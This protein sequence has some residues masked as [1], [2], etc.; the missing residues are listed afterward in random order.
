MTTKSGKQTHGLDRFFSSLFGKPVPG[1]AF[2]GLS[3]IDVQ[4][5]RS[6]PVM[7]EQVVRTEEE[8]TAAKQ[9]AQQRQPQK[10]Q[11]QE[12]KKPGRPKGSKNRNKAEVCLTPE[13]LRI[14]EMIKQFLLIAGQAIPLVYIARDRHF[15]NNN[16]LQMVLQCGLHLVSKLRCDS[17]LYFAYQGPDTRRKYGAR[18][19]DANIPAEYLKET[20]TQDDIRTDIYQM[21]AL[22]KE[23]AQPLNVVIIVK[24]NLKT[25]AWAHVV[26]F[27]S[28]LCQYSV[29][30]SEP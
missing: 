19:D 22:H 21:T 18:I 26:L 15:G 14:Q 4:E 25:G 2:F 8:K 23:F 6:Y 10:K 29:R 1:I 27:S 12:K 20:T 11:G 9:K 3:L 24:T 30:H 13:L 5:R 7:T 16:A 17:A 28:P